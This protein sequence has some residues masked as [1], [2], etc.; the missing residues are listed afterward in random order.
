MKPEE[1][2]PTSIWVDPVD[3]PAL[4]VVTVGRLGGAVGAVVTAAVPSTTR[5]ALRFCT[6]RHP[7]AMPTLTRR[8]VENM[9]AITTMVT[10][11]VVVGG[12]DESSR[13]AS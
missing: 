9:M 2:S 11:S 13:R 4:V 3:D 7:T 8:D 10:L 5:A 1:Q 12:S 6:R